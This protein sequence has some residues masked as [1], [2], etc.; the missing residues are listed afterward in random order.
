M[1][2]LILQLP[3]DEKNL[4]KTVLTTVMEEPCDFETT[5]FYK[6]PAMDVLNLVAE[7]KVFL[8]KG[9]AYVTE[10]Q[11]ADVMYAEFQRRFEMELQV[12]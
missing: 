5:D 12:C 9:I 6:I 10:T 3:N 1:L 2:P 11:L 8:E 7:R 4:Y